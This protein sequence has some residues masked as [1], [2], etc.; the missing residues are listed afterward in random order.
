MTKTDGGGK[1]RRSEGE[2]KSRVRW[3]SV[4]QCGRVWAGRSST[5]W[6][7]SFAIHPNIVGGSLTPPPP[8]TPPGLSDSSLRPPTQVS[9][10]RRAPREEGR[11]REG[12]EDE[13][14]KAG[15]KGGREEEGD[16]RGVWR[17]GEERIR[18]TTIQIN[19][20]NI[21]QHQTTQTTIST[22]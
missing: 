20:S 19:T 13:G 5:N 8:A 3:Y 18:T 7:H 11:R 9:P 10:T 1:E 21:K 6:Y 4:V 17:R 2:T 14:G 16:G 15:T 22:V 12:G